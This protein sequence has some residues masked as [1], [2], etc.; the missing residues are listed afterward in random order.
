MVAGTGTI[1]PDEL[2]EILRRLG[3][4]LTDQELNDMV[5]QADANQDGV[6]DY[7]EV[8]PAT[9]PHA[10]SATSHAIDL[11]CVL[12]PEHYVLSC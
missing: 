3:Q 9:A 11:F 10:A 8:R 5:R 12:R 1:N 6:I 7:N 2:R 4:N